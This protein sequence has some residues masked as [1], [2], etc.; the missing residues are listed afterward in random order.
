[1]GRVRSQLG[2]V[3]APLAYPLGGERT[4]ARA[5]WVSGGKGLRDALE[6]FTGGRILVLTATPIYKCPAAPYEAAMLSNAHLRKQRL[7][8][9]ARVD[10]YTAEPGPLG[11]AA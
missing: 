7:G 10:I 11:V 4:I 9:E 1:M 6:K 5:R 3:Q 8:E 2:E